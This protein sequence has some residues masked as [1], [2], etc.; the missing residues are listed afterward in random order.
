[1]KYRITVRGILDQ[2]WAAWLDK[3]EMTPL[4]TE[5]A[6]VTMLRVDLPDQPALLGLLNRLAD[7][8][9]TLISFQL[10]GD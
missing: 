6:P 10:E 2:S 4:D 3:A 9:L 5:A 8:N 7:L 1:M